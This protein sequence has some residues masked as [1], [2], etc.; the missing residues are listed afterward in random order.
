ML[1]MRTGFRA[2]LSEVGLAGSGRLEDVRDLMRNVLYRDT[3]K[4]NFDRGRGVELFP[5]W[6]ANAIPGVGRC[7]EFEVRLP[8]RCPELVGVDVE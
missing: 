3:K 2:S 1:F 6:L 5:E 4:R 8:M 7:Q